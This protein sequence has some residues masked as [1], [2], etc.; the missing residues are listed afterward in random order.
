MKK[1]LLFTFIIICGYNINAQKINIS[2]GGLFG[3]NNSFLD[4]KANISPDYLAMDPAYIRNLSLSKTS[5]NGFGYNLGLYIS[6]QPEK[7]RVSLET[8]IMVENLNN[9]YTLSSSWEQYYA[10]TG[11]YWGP[12][13]ETEIID[14]SFSILS[15]PI[16]LG[17][18]L[19]QKDKY[20]FT[21]FGGAAPDI[22]MKNDHMKYDYSM[23]EIYLYK[24]LYLSYQSGISLSFNKIFASLKYERSL[25]IKKTMSRDY[26]PYSMSVEKLYL[27]FLSISFG[28]R[29]N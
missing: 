28:I 3:I 29:L 10:T 9:T 4:S 17:Y 20:K 7:S 8:G 19:I 12:V 25:N 14:N 1:Y 15:I 21:I 16:V 6:A 23:Q 22:S 18:D 5:S 26:F 24:P 27:N 2:Y 11:S 13:A